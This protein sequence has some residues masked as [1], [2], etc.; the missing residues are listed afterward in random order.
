MFVIAIRYFSLLIC[1]VIF[2]VN[3]ISC[4]L[5][6][7]KVSL[8]EDTRQDLPYDA[9]DPDSD[10]YGIHATAGWR[11]LPI[12]FRVG[13]GFDSTFN[14]TSKD[15]MQ[16]ILRAIKTWETA[17]GKKLFEF[18][19]VH[20]EVQG[21]TFKDL[22]TSLSDSV[23]GHYLDEDW[24]KTG[25]P[26]VVLATTIWENEGGSV[27]AIKTADIRFNSD[28]YVFGDSLTLQYDDNVGKEVVDMESLALHEL[29]HLLGLSHIDEG[30]DMFSVMNPSLL[31]GTGL[32]SRGVS[33]GDIRRIQK[34]Y[35]C[36]G[37]ACDMSKVIEKLRDRFS[38]EE[39]D[40][41][42]SSI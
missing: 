9:T 17:V 26:E 30:V 15:Q 28:F 16:G 3:F 7:Y 35:G 21:D 27:E 14:L 40:Q 18:R 19:G 5:Q 20:K 25:K 6:F 4:G 39:S 13:S 23:N 34:I 37:E 32:T 33:E 12:P 1:V 41:D 2:F 11:Q 24:G 8:D 10:F 42:L 22:Y 36:H 31:I 38:D 29:G